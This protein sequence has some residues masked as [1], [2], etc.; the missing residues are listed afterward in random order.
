MSTQLTAP[1]PADQVEVHHVKAT[2][3]DKAVSTVSHVLLIIWSIIVV[4]P[5]LW[6]L[7]TAFKTTS[8][9]FSSPFG[10]PKKLQWVNFTNAWNTAGIGDYFVNTVFNYP[11][12][13]ECYKVAALNA[14]NKLAG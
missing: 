12:L 4:G 11:T 6:T 2:A 14:F 7:M 3:G 13:A 8:E 10:L 1:L 5:L 9:I